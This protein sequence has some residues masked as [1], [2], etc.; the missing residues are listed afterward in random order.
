MYVLHSL[1]HL[2]KI[3]R[4]GWGTWNKN[5]S[6]SQT[7]W[8][9]LTKLNR[10]SKSRVLATSEL[11]LGA[12]RCLQLYIFASYCWVNCCQA[13]SPVSIYHLTL[14]T[15][16]A[17]LL[18]N[19]PSYPIHW[20]GCHGTWWFHLC[21]LSANESSLVWLLFLPVISDTLH[22]AWTV[23][24]GFSWQKKSIPEGH[25]KLKN[26]MQTWTSQQHCYGNLEKQVLQESAHRQLSREELLVQDQNLLPHPCR[27]E[28]F[29]PETQPHLVLIWW[30]L[31]RQISQKLHSKIIWVQ[32]QWTL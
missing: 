16:S 19:R 21:H 25:T 14:C 12:V 5:V 29:L 9:E 10:D 26:I 22:A 3:L 31:Y 13:A 28:R 1:P 6:H 27:L 32:A 17:P 18:W 4:K 23:E 24:S 30:H 15:V 8:C 2:L 11:Y 7:V 20:I